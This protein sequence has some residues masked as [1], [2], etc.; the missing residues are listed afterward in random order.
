MEQ[1][2]F[3]SVV[4]K[5][6]NAE[7]IEDKLMKQNIKYDLIKDPSRPTTFKKRY[8]VENQKIFRVSRLNDH[9]LDKKIENKILQKIKDKAPFMNG[10]VIP[11]FVYGVIT[12]NLIKEILIMAK[13]YNLIFLAI[14]NVVHK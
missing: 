6:N 10:I 3:L 9:L 1:I 8:V 11:D 13:K 4:G 7:I 12:E 2:T 14:C 5:D